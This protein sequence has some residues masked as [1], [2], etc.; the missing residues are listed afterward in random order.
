V[1]D[2]QSNLIATYEMDDVVPEG[3]T[4]KGVE[5]IF[6]IYWTGE[7]NQLLAAKERHKSG[8]VAIFDP[9]SGRFLYR[10]KEKADRIYVADVSGDWR[11]E[12]IVLNGNELHIYQNPEDNP[13]PSHQSL[14][15]ENHYRRNKLTWNYYS[16]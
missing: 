4:A 9:L 13:N 12:L 7:P 15:A 6:T 8:D 5:V 10:F 14:W 1:F 11:E 2:A 16:P 3:W